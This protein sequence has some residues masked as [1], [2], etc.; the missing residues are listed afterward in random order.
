[1]LG[2]RNVSLTR[3]IPKTGARFLKDKVIGNSIG[4]VTFLVEYGC[5][6][7]DLNPG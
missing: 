4:L 7:R 6:R 3:H 1:M 2:L 5:G